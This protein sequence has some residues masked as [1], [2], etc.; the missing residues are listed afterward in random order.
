[1]SVLKTYFRFFKEPQEALPQLVRARAFKEACL[2]YLTAALSC[3]VLCNLGDSLSI[4]VF[5]F[6]TAI[7]FVTEVTAGYILASFCALFLD[8]G[9]VET[10]PAQL[11]VLVGFSGF[12]K[13]LLMVFVLLCA[14]VPAARLFLLAPCVF[15]AVWGL[16]L[17]FLTRGVMRLY[18]ATAGKSLGAWLFALV[19]V[20]VVFG[21]SAVFFVWTLVLLF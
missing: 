15:V 8:F 20:V 18:G 10:S 14:T 16:Q 2:G 17:A 3:V 19:P 1:M 12:I 6:K 13:S 21:L 5:V 7:L 11:F 4:P 9:K